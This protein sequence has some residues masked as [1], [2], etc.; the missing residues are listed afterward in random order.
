MLGVKKYLGP[1]G[2]AAVINVNAVLYSYKGA[3]LVEVV[4]SLIKSSDMIIHVSILD[5]H[6]MLRKSKFEHLYN[7]DYQHQFWDKIDGPTWFKEEK[8]FDDKLPAEYT[9]VL[10]DDTLLGEGWLEKCI[11]FI[12]GNKQ[13]I[14]SGKNLKRV[15]NKDKHF[16]GIEESDSNIFSLSNFAD[17][18]F[19]FGYT[20]TFRMT[21]YPRDIK[22]LGEDEMFS[23]RCHERDIVIYSGPTNLYHDFGIRTLETLYT[24]FS[25]EHN[26]NN[27]ID[28]LDTDV[29]ESWL[30]K[31]HIDE[32]PIKLFYQD[33]DVE[34]DP[35]KLKFLDFAGERFIGNTKAIY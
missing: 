27:L 35:Y 14:V 16:L 24:P 33:N 32:K 18:N 17:K 31:I 30:K 26:Y 25:I 5:Q 28:M 22:Y 1:Q 10:S 29:G 19:I 34:Y 8:I 6:P 13:V 2:A 11:E 7:V 12:N 23:I 15:T 20:E 9:L 21:G 4:E 3:H